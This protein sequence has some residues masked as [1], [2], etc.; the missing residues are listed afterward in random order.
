MNYCFKNN[1]KSGYFFLDR[2]S[3]YTKSMKIIGI[4]AIGLFLVT[5][6]TAQTCSGDFFDSGGEFGVY[7]NNEDA[8]W[9][10]CPNDPA[11][12]VIELFFTSF[13]VDCTDS[14]FVYDGPAITATLIGGFCGP[15]V[16]N[17]PLF[18]SA[19][20]VSGC[21]TFRF[22]S[23]A[24]NFVSAGW[25]AG[26]DCK[27]IPPITTLN[28]PV[29]DETITFTG[30]HIIA[31]N[32]ILGA[33]D[34]DLIA[35]EV[36]LKPG[37]EVEAGAT[38]QVTIDNCAPPSPLQETPDVAADA[39][40]S[41]T[42]ITAP[43]PIPNQL[44]IFPNPFSSTSTIQFTLEQASVMELQLLDFSG[45]FLQNIQPKSHYEVGH[46][47]IDLQNEQW[48]SGIYFISLTSSNQQFVER[49]MVLGN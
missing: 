9:T 47:Q 4:T 45:R 13:D 31:D 15:S 43:D 41:P 40:Q 23:N 20:T 1:N 33:S 32:S 38:F 22:Q 18:V 49:V 5:A 7:S 36:T 24:D 3:I 6:S 42:N 17:G 26:I 16:T 2:F 48:Q 25:R 30:N 44:T 12:E 28:Y 27:E 8:T 39:R 34:I 19:S 46:H 14:L 37:F 10:F 21:L 35:C 11:S 29:Q